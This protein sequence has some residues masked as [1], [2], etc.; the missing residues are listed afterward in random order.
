ML[1]ACVFFSGLSVVFPPAVAA[2]SEAA[3]FPEHRREFVA[4]KGLCQ[5]FW[6]AHIEV[7]AFFMR[8]NREIWSERRYADGERGG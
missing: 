1:D 7:E 6:T 3:Q 5:V 2:I 4:R 8:R